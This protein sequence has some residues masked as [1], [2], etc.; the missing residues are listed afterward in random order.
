MQAENRSDN[1][2]RAGVAQQPL[3]YHVGESRRR[4]VREHS[5]EMEAGSIQAE[6]GLVQQ[7]PKR[8]QR[9]IK[10]RFC[11]RQICP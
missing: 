6:D 9:P 5:S 8:K 2:R 4:N 11:I 1:E 3:R 10:A 7:E